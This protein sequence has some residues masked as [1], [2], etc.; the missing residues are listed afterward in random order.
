MHFDL[1]LRSARL[2]VGDLA[3]FS[4][5]PRDGGEGPSGLWRAQLGTQWHQRL[6]AETAAEHPASEFEVAVEGAIVQRGWTVTLSGR[7]DQLIRSGDLLTLREI[8]T[9]TRILPADEAELRADYPAYFAQLAAYA[10]LLALREGSPRPRAELLFVEVD[11]GLA[12]TVPLSPADEL[13]FRLQ[14]GR[15]TEFLDLRLRARDRR[16]GLRFR[17]AFAALRPGQEAVQRELEAAQRERPS[18]LLLEAP[19]GFGKTGVLLEF[20]L[21]RLRSGD[22][23]RVIYLTSKST[24]QLQVVRTLA[25][26]TGPAAGEPSAGATPVAAWHVRN[27]GE[28]CVNAV[29]HCVRDACAFLDGAVARW[30]ESGLSRFYRFEDQPHELD[31]LRAAGRAAVICPYEITRTALA[32]QDVWI[33]DYNYVFAPANRGLFYHQPGFQPERTLVVIDEAHNLPGRVAGAH[34]HAFAAGDASAVCLALD[35]TGAPSAFLAAWE[36]WARFLASLAISR[37]WPPTTRSKP[38]ACW[39]NWRS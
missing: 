11:S 21:G 22:F 29:F 38:G 31:D 17:P 12:Q 26:M 6:R 19:T 16:L 36:E 4:V 7:I 2:G 3:D 30:P 14:L 37:R 23:D 34:S 5:G 10:A 25:A 1:D 24:G 33:G 8:K 18:A 27:K 13:A 20:A 39:R 28:H 15:V 9:V 32:F 35:Q